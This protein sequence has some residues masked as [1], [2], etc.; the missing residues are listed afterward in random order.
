[1]VSVSTKVPLWICEGSHRTI[2]TVP[3][4]REK[5]LVC[6]KVVRLATVLP[7]S[8]IFADGD[9]FHDG[10]AWRDGFME[11]LSAVGTVR[12][13]VQF[14]QKGYSLSDALHFLPK[15]KSAF[16]K[17]FFAITEKRPKFVLGEAY[18]D[19]LPAQNDGTEDRA[20]PRQSNSEERAAPAAP[21]GPSQQ[22]ASKTNIRRFARKSRKK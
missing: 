4:S 19:I 18:S 21:A 14:V 2:R 8:V 17:P 3:Q 22:R 11:S 1:M 16:L 6:V 10:P 20:A 15:F 5:K 13:H 12:Y 9:I 7:Y